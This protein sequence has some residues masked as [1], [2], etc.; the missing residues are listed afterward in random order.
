MVRHRCRKGSSRSESRNNTPS[1]SHSGS[2]QRVS[3]T[4]S[5]NGRSGRSRHDTATSDRSRSNSQRT[6]AGGGASNDSSSPSFVHVPISTRRHRSERTVGGASVTVG[7]SS[8]SSPL[9]DSAHVGSRSSHPVVK[10][11]RPSPP[12]RQPPLHVKL[13][14]GTSSSA[15]SASAAATAT[16]TSPTPTRLPVPPSNDDEEEDPCPICLDKRTDEAAILYCMHRYC[17]QCIKRW[18]EGSNN[19]CPLCKMIFS[20]IAFNIQSDSSYDVYKIKQRR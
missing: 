1:S 9:L 19:T 5:S 6:R 10:S 18:A 20:E 14:I 12:T 16:S 2:E 7:R 8:A 15:A 13:R 4:S 3:T 11:G 17:F